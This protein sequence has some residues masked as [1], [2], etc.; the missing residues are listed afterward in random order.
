MIETGWGAICGLGSS[1]LLSSTSSRKSGTACVPCGRICGKRLK[2]L[3]PLL[4]ESMER[5]GHMGLAPEIRAK[6]LAGS[7]SMIDGALSKIRE[8]G[9]RQRHRPVASALRRNPGTDVRRLEG[10]GA[11]LIEADLVAHSGPL[12]ARQF[13]YRRWC[14]RILR[15]VGRSV[16]RCWCASKRSCAP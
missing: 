8:E 4:I 13:L 2:A 3:L 15:P 9:G 14:S 7:A 16:R 10:S 5:N 11:R 12:G 6:L 1:I